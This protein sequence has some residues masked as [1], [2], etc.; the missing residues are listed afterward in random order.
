MWLVCW[1]GA[2][3][4]VCC[5]WLGLTLV[6]RRVVGVLWCVV[7]LACCC[8]YGSL[9]VRRFVVGAVASRWFVGVL[10][11]CWLVVVRLV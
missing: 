7:A 5:C 1:F 9:L 3:A 4:L 6:C 2:I 10:L 8:V 11:V